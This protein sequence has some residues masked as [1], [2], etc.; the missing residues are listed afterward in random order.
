M[1]FRSTILGILSL[2]HQEEEV[3]PDGTHPMLFAVSS[4]VCM[5]TFRSVA[6]FFFL[7]KVTFLRVFEYRRGVDI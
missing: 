3:W 6:S 7:A 5:P 2:S 1:V 4:F